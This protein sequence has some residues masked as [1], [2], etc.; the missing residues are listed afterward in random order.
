MLVIVYAYYEARGLLYGP[1]IYV[2]SDLTGTHDPLVIIS[3]KA[4]RI[5]QLTMNGKPVPVTE[6]GAFEEPYLLVSGYNHIILRAQNKYGRSRERVI[7]VM[8][9]PSATSTATISSSTQPVAP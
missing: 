6:E 4:E 9:Q 2:S 3:G 5:S 1:S 8:Y 7:E